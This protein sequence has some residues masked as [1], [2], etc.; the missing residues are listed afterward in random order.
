MIDLD[1]ER[2]MVKGWRGRRFMACRAADT[3]DRIIE[4]IGIDNGADLPPE[5]GLPHMSEGLRNELHNQ[6]AVLLRT[7]LALN[8]GN[9]SGTRL[10]RW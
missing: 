1:E 4:N 8:D 10:Q 2:R 9:T 3:L 5:R 6:A 7:I